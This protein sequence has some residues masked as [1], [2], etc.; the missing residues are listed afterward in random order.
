MYSFKQ[1][2][3]IHITTRNHLI[4]WV[5]ENMDFYPFLQTLALNT[6]VP[7]RGKNLSR[8]WYSFKHFQCKTIKLSDP[9]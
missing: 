8:F 3:D 9:V 6:E 4:N 5:S 7:L 2:I 1:T